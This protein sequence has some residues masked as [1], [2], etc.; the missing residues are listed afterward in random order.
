MRLT[1]KQKGDAADL[2]LQEWAERQ[3]PMGNW[4]YDEGLVVNIKEISLT[5]GRYLRVWMMGRIERLIGLTLEN[6]SREAVYY[7]KSG[8]QP[9]VGT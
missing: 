7:V 9:D 5:R 6:T 3:T 4:V 1:H 8:R 2:C